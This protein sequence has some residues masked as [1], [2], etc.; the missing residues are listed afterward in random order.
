VHFR[1][2]KG[3]YPS[4]NMNTGQHQCFFCNQP[5]SRTPLLWNNGKGCDIT[6]MDIFQQGIFNNSVNPDHKKAPNRPNTNN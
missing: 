2:N 5:R 1:V 4:S 3:K 6:G